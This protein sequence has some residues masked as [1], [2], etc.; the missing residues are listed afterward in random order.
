M[1]RAK[2]MAGHVHS[3]VEIQM[4]EFAKSKENG[5]Q[6]MLGQDPSLVGQTQS[7]LTGSLGAVIRFG[8]GAPISLMQSCSTEELLDTGALTA[9]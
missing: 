6:S 9:R 2:I 4:L 8:E 5:S 7:V 1:I 3:Q